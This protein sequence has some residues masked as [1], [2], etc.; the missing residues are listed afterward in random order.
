MADIWADFFNKLEVITQGNTDAESLNYATHL[1]LRYQYI[2]VETPKVACSSIK[3]ALQR[4]E[5]EMPDFERKNFEDL[6][7]REFSPLLQLTQLPNFEQHLK[8]SDFL[9]FCFVRNP[10]TRLLSCYLD[11][12]I[13]PSI[14]KEKESLMKFMGLNADDIAYPISFS[15]F[16]D[17]IEKQSLLEMDYHW[18]PQTYLTCQSTIKYDFIGKL[19]KFENDFNEVGKKISPEIGKYYSPEVR[20]QTDANNMLKKYYD[21]DLFSRVYDIYKVDFDNFSYN[22]IS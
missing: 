3:M 19:E 21:K 8:G 14:P 5:L 9:K 6:H 17:Q 22:K 13:N 20:H 2:F 18:R 11:K 12:I 15:D 7:V 1:S 16:V 10:Y 4:L